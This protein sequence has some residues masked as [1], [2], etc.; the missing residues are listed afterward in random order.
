MTYGCRKCITVIQE[1]FSVE[2]FDQECTQTKQSSVRG[3]KWDVWEDKH[4][5]FL[6]E[7]KWKKNALQRTKI[8][9]IKNVRKCISWGKLNICI[10]DNNN[11]N[12]KEES[13]HGDFCSWEGENKVKE[14]CFAEN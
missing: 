3:W 4:G 14:N 12:V 2:D 7:K 6:R 8:Y 1:C 10:R 5:L 13:Y 9:K 11:K